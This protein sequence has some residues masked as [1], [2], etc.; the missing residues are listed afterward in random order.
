MPPGEG[1]SGAVLVDQIKS[2]DWRARKPQYI[3]KLPHVV[4]DDVLALLEALL[5]D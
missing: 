3:C 5:W 4:I 2:L 1:V